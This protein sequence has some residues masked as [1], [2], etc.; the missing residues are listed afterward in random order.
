MRK[1]TLMLAI[2][3]EGVGMVDKFIWRYKTTHL[4][5]PEHFHF[6]PGFCYGIVASKTFKLDSV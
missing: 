4:C 6:C 3:A 2:Y 5:E 1:Q